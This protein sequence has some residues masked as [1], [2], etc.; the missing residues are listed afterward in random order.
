MYSFV[1]QNMD[2]DQATAVSTS[3]TKG[4]GAEYKSYKCT[5]VPLK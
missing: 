1:R 4:G 3:E 5:Q 2:P